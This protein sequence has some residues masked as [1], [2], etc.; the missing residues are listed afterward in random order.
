MVTTHRKCSSQG[1]GASEFQLQC[2]C[3]KHL[4]C[5]EQVYSCFLANLSHI[6]LIATLY[7]RCYLQM[8][9]L[10]LREVKSPAQGH[11]ALSSRTNWN[12]RLPDVKFS[13]PLRQVGPQLCLYPVFLFFL[14][15][16]VF[17]GSTQISSD[18]IWL[19]FTTV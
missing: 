17:P 7:H 9:Q 14:P 12:S 3:L 5:A 6:T 11:T 4:L 8:R 13:F 1:R 18:N 15:L 2:A 16:N 19:S 10:R